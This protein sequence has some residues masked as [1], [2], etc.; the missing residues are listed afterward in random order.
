MRRSTLGRAA[1]GAACV[2]A[3][4]TVYFWPGSSDPT[5]SAVVPPP[6]ASTAAAAL[7]SVSPTSP[8]VQPVR[9]T[10]T[11]TAERDRRPPTPVSNL[12]LA[13]NTVATF[14]VS[15]GPASDASGVANYQ[16]L[17]NGYIV[18]LVPREFAVLD[19]PA[20]V[21]PL[22]VQVAALDEAGNRSEWRAI[23]IIPPVVVAPTVDDPPPPLDESPT[24]PPASALPSA[25]PSTTPTASGTPSPSV[26][27]ATSGTPVPSSSFVDP[28]GHI[29]PW[30]IP[31]FWASG[32]TPAP[33]ETG[34][35]TPTATATPVAPVSDLSVP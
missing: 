7:P 17:L 15:W 32:V 34:T 35:G 33:T 9:T 16:V 1:L 19:W 24:S 2:V 21:E 20:D 25:G 8:V 14:T 29:E 18:A 3:A 13:G 11:P 12:T 31:T 22:L 4:L 28:T 27:S 26:T 10:A 30:P 23:V 6:T 5:E